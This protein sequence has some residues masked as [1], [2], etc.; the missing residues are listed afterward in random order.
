MA[1]G[2]YTLSKEQCLEIGGHCFEKE[3]SV[4]LTDPPIYHRTCKHC[5]LVQEGRSQPDIRWSDDQHQPWLDR[6]RNG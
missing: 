6:R 3:R 1:E 4:I 2:K 5:G